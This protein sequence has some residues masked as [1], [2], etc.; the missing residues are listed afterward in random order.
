[1]IIRFIVLTIFSSYQML[2]AQD[3]SK[4]Q[5]QHRLVLLI[6][7]Q[8]DNTIAREQMDALL[9]NV[10]GL[11]ERK[12]KIYEIKADRYRVIPLADREK[13][14][15]WSNQSD[16]YQRYGR[17]TT[18]FEIILIGLDGSVKLRQPTFLPIHDLFAVIDAMP[19]RRSEIGKKN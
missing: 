1:M 7:T 3:I 15:N 8:P 2:S 17:E 5:W 13:K 18:P 19:M 12:I 11:E 14:D 6:S 4:H 10:K 16:L 9:S